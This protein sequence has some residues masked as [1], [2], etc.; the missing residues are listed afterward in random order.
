[1][2]RI[3]SVK[4]G[5]FASYTLAQ[6]PIEARYL[7]IGLFTEADDTG[8]LIDSPKKLAGTLFPHDEKITAAKVDGWLNRLAAIGSVLRYEAKGGH[9]IAIPEWSSHQKVSHPLPSQLPN[10]SL[11]ALAALPNGSGGI[12]E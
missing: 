4:P 3:R 6:V 8:R 7:F 10:P 9:Y 5:L 11:A 12:P 1:M 2:A